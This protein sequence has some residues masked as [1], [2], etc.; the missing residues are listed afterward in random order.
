MSD[1]LDTFALVLAIERDAVGLT[2]LDPAIITDATARTDDLTAQV[3]AG[4]PDGVDE[5]DALTDILDTLAMFRR[6]KIAAAVGR[7]RPSNMLPTEAVYFDA[8]SAAAAAL[9]EAWG[10]PD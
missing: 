4:D 3:R 8:I 5:I 6:Q 2:R 9:N 7:A 1:I 10:L